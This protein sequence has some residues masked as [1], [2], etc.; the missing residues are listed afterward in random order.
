MKG[1]LLQIAVLANHQNGRDTHIR[2]ARSNPF[3]GKPVKPRW[4]YITLLGC[5]VQVR[6]FGPRSDP[7]KALGHDVAFTSPQFGAYAHVR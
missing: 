5:V 2:Q 7:V 3:C 1:F 6:V 4:M